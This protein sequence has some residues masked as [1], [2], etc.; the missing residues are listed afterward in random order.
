MRF[1]RLSVIAAVLL[2]ACGQSDVTDGSGSTTSDGKRVVRFVAFGDAGRANDNQ[3]AVANAMAQVCAIKGCD[4]A[5]ELGDNI[6]D[7]G[8]TSVDDE[9]F[10]TKFEEPYSVLDFPIYLTLGNHDNSASSLGLGDNNS[11]GEYQ[12]E[13]SAAEQNSGRWRM[14][15]RY[16]AFTAPL[17]LKA[18]ETPIA[19]FFSLDANPLAAS[20]QNPLQTEY[21]YT[22]YGAAQLQWF[23]AA[24]SA[25]TAKWTFAFS[26]HP[27]VSNGQHGNAGSFD[28][29]NGTVFPGTTSGTPW[30]EFLDA[31]ACNPDYNGGVDMMLY[32]HDHDMQWLK[33]VE[34]CNGKTEFVLSGGG[35]DTREF[36]DPESNQAY[37]QQD[38]TPGFFWF[39]VTDGTL[40]GEA[41]LLDN[42]ELPLD[43][44]GKPVPAYT[45]SFSK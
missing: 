44:K 18:G 5:L 31:S 27:Y 4:F 1:S 25:S 19:E 7:S 16:Y 32:G 13:Y 8:V 34:S 33:P 35:S 20:L 3:Y 38:L 29:F 30:K 2:A 14:P 11:K 28:G 45:R 22:T 23:Q 6:Y 9:Q 42:L 26:H 37:W 17:D 36:G 10:Q 15:A 21:Y 40:T 43:G 39:E 41:Y 24:L 12:V